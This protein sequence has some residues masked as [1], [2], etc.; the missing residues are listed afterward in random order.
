MILALDAG[1]SR[2]KYKLWQFDKE[3]LVVDQGVVDYSQ[4]EQGLE[5]FQQYN[6]AQCLVADVSSHQVANKVQAL[7]LSQ[8]LFEV[9]SQESLLGVKNSYAEPHRLGVDRFLAAIEAYYL[10]GKKAVCVIDVGTAGKCD[11]IDAGGVHCGGHIV[12]GLSLLRDSL[13]QGTSKVRFD[14]VEALQT[15]WGASTQEAVEHGTWAMLLAW[16]QQQMQQ[17]R[18]QFA[19]GDVYLAGG[20]AIDV[21]QQLGLENVIIHEDLVVD[22]LRRLA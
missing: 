1:N 10:S 13:L 19:G 4:L 21:Q 3:L 8:M 15:G 12:P 7:N 6:I 9:H 14:A 18:A 11:V 22:A 5:A 2:L 20:L 17:F 16:V